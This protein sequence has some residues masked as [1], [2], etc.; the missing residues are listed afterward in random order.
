M[1][2]PRAAHDAAKLEETGPSDEGH[3]EWKRLKVQKG[4]AQA[5]DRETLIPAHQVWRD[6]GLERQLHAPGG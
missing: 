2:K 4:L 6:I 1:M 3:E 5:A